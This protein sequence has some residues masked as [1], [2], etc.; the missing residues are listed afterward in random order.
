MFPYPELAAG[1]PGVTG[2]GIH[3]I[4]AVALVVVLAVDTEAALADKESAEKEQA[5]QANAAPEDSRIQARSD[6]IASRNMPVVYQVHPA[7]ARVAAVLRFP[8]F[9]ST[10]LNSH[11]FPDKDIIVARF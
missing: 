5:R 8:L 9:Y 6:R 10:L 2:A 1:T 3:P 7:V 11:A 4:L